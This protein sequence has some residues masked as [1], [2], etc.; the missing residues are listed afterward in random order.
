LA[1]WRRPIATL[2]EAK[3]A[4]ERHKPTNGK[5]LFNSQ[6]DP[7]V[8]RVESR[9]VSRRRASHRESVI[10]DRHQIVTENKEISKKHRT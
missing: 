6:S 9:P 3:A 8:I 10:F 4:C 2:H 1:E 7:F 5:P